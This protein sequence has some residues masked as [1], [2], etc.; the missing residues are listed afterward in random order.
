MKYKVTTLANTIPIETDIYEA[1]TSKEALEM[2][3]FDCME[4]CNNPHIIDFEDYGYE[5]E[6]DWIEDIHYCPYKNG[7]KLYYG[8]ELIRRY[9]FR[10]EKC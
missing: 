3:I 7:F 10:V 2:A 4:M 9:T 6:F 8:L 5:N 1:D